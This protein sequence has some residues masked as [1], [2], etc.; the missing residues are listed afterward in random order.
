MTTTTRAFEDA[1]VARIRGSHHPPSPP[2]RQ[3]EADVLDPERVVL[4]GLSAVEVE[5]Y[6]RAAV[7]AGWAYVEGSLRLRVKG[8]RRYVRASYARLDSPTAPWTPAEL[9]R[10]LLLCG[11]DWQATA[12]ALGS[13][14]REIRR[15]MDR[16]EF[17]ALAPLWEPERERLSLVE[18]GQ[19]DTRPEVRRD[20]RAVQAALGGSGPLVAVVRLVELYIE[21]VESDRE[22]PEGIIE[23]LRRA[24]WV[25]AKP[26]RRWGRGARQ[27]RGGR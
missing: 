8:G 19:A 7:H 12:A 24:G 27:G 3:Y 6:V 1:V 5:S 9:R 18:A 10:E 16:P 11:G 25:L 26:V 20:A 17:A 4:K 22:V 13:P 15:W 2:R 21:A 23:Y 14:Y